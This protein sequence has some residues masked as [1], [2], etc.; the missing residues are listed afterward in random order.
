MLANPNATLSGP[1]F[2]AWLGS[3]D[4]NAATLAVG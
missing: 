1:P 2:A 4:A 3:G